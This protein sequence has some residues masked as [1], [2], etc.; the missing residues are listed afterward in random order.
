[1]PLTCG[2]RIDGSQQHE[3]F[4]NYDVSAGLK[5]TMLD[6]DSIVFYFDVEQ[7]PSVSP[8]NGGSV[9][10]SSP[11]F[12]WSRLVPEGVEADS[13]H[14]QLD[15]YHDFRSSPTLR[16]DIND[17]LVP[18]VTCPGS[19][20]EDSIY[21]W[22]VQ[23]FAG[24]FWSEFSHAFAARSLVQCC[25][26]YTFGFTGNTD[27]DFEGKMNLQDVTRLI[28]RIYLSRLDLCCEENGDT[29]ADG[30]MNLQDVTRLIDHI[31]MSKNPT[32]QCL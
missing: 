30:T 2:I 29:N 7:V 9:A 27:C 23:W 12:N 14:F 13:F 28:D 20:G 18:Q 4:S 24:G 8:V 10:M 32:A 3:I 31:Y 5:S 11:T 16:Y 17:L 6:N 22:R 15:R 21:Y 25:G 19:L 1:M 26:M